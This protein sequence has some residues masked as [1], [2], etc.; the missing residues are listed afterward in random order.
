MTPT[1][2][3]FPPAVFLIWQIGLILTLVVFVPLAV[4]YLHRVFKAARMIQL[5]AADTLTAA[6]GIAGNTQHIS[7]LDATI[8][9][10]GQILG[11]A[12]KVAGKLGTVADVLEQRAAS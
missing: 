2:G 8:E 9:V 12:G 4:Y 5:Y 3:L 10:A 1:N 7:A 6:A 11:T